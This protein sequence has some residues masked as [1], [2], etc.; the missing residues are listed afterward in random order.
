MKII[1]KVG[2]FFVCCLLLVGCG[3]RE[4]YT[5]LKKEGS[6]YIVDN[7]RFYYP[8]RFQLDGDQTDNISI[9]FHDDMES[10]YYEVHEDETVNEL[11]DR[12]E[13]YVAELEQEGASNIVVSEPILESGLKVYEITGSFLDTGMRFKHIVYFTQTHTYVYAYLAT[14]EDYDKNQEEMTE[15]LHSIVVEEIVTEDIKEE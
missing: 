11:T 2:A 9:H 7:V 5:N 6:E 1:W 3:S 4:E 10:V 8:N 14:I 13:L 15:F 12:D